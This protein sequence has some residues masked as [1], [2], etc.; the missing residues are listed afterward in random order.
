MTQE[1]FNALMDAYLAQRGEG[2]YMSK[3][4]GEEMDA[5]LDSISGGGGG[6]ITSGTED[7]PDGAELASGT[8]YVKYE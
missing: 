6:V 5:L 7:L 8:I 2:Y 1:E 3:Y 4:S